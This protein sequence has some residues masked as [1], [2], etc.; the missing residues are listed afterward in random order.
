MPNLTEPSQ[1][2]EYAAYEAD[3]SQEEVTPEAHLLALRPS[4]CPNR[5]FA[6]RS[7]VTRIENPT[8][9]TAPHTAPVQTITNPGLEMW[10]V[11]KS[12]PIFATTH[13]ITMDSHQSMSSQSLG[14]II[15]P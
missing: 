5:L 12:H 6:R 14:F 9:D 2:H 11:Q 1:P 3:P 15:A 4:R 8:I 7:R 10:A 13:P